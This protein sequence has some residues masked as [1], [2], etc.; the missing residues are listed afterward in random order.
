MNFR[1]LVYCLAWLC[2]VFPVAAKSNLRVFMSDEIPKLEYEVLKF[3]RKNATPEHWGFFRYLSRV[4]LAL[5]RQAVFLGWP[6]RKEKDFYFNF[7]IIDLNGDGVDEIVAV[8]TNTAFFCGNQPTCKGTMYQKQKSGW[9]Y[10][11]GLMTKESDEAL[12]IGNKRINGWLVIGEQEQGWWGRE[13][14]YKVKFWRCWTPAFEG[15]GKIDTEFDHY[16]MPYIHGQAG[17]FGYVQDDGSCLPW[18]LSK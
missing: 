1:T 17:Y 11:G 4:P 16:H 13:G 9:A 5:E 15:S 12:V 14:E 10:I 6:D 8:V 7:R 2:L 3:D 18:R